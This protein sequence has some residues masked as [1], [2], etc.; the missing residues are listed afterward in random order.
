MGIVVRPFAKVSL[1]YGQFFSL[2]VY[3]IALMVHYKRQ[4]RIQAISV[5]CV[6]K[7]TPE[8]PIALAYAISAAGL[9]GATVK[10]ADVVERL[11]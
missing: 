11:S 2:S 5:V 9:T 4:S 3:G 6:R 10:P 8:S 1:S 7:V